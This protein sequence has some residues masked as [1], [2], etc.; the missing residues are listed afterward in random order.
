MPSSAAITMCRVQAATR[1]VCRPTVPM[2]RGTDVKAG[3]AVEAGSDMGWQRYI[4]ENGLTVSM[5]G[6][7]ASAPGGTNMEKN[8]FTVDNVVETAL[9]V[10]KMS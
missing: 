5:S 8:G 3:I 6:Y 7:G 2:G 9:K 4:G 10:T 1:R